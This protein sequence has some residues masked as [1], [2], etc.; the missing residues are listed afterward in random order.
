[1]CYRWLRKIYFLGPNLS[2][3]V[4]RTCSR[5]EIRVFHWRYW[6]MITIV[7]SKLNISWVSTLLLIS[8]K[9]QRWWLLCSLVLRL[10]HDLVFALLSNW[11]KV[12]IEWPKLKSM[13]LFSSKMSLASSQ[14][15]YIMTTGHLFNYNH[16]VVLI[17][18]L[19]TASKHYVN[20]TT[21]CSS[22]MTFD[23][24]AQLFL[25]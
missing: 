11:L 25:H 20:I 13:L 9:L 14:P 12:N 18:L 5:L 21:H 6:P 2:G 24:I 16:Y 15:P 8:L 23:V 10:V 22:Q 17:F 3:R 19:W 1:M 4:L 7:E